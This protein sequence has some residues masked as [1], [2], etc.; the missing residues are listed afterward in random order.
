MKPT[1]FI[2]IGT[3]KPQI[4]FLTAFLSPKKSI[5]LHV[6]EGQNSLG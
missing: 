5:I 3:G 4:E 6:R 1:E 2:E